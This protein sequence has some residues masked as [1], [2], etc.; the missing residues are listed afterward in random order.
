[1]IRLNGTGGITESLEKAGKEPTT[2]AEEF[3]ER[4]GYDPDFLDGWSIPLPKATG[5]RAND[6]RK[7]RRGGAGSELKY[8]NFSVILSVSRRMPM[9]TACNIDGEQSRRLPRIQTWSFDGRLD[10]EDQW[11]MRSMIAT[12]GLAQQRYAKSHR[13]LANCRGVK[14][15]RRFRNSQDGTWFSRS[16]LGA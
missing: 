1:M 5:E 3:E 15:F 9:L 7:L 14:D 11:G 12:L 4:N 8:R 13:I 16:V 10:K 2:P 6:V